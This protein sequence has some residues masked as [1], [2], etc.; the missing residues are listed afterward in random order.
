[1]EADGTNPVGI[2]DGA[3]NDSD[4]NWQPREVDG[5][6]TVTKTVVG[7]PASGTTFEITIDCD[8][9]D[10]DQVLTFGETG[11]TQVIERESFGPLE[12]QVT[13]TVTG[14]ATTV[15]IMCGAGKNAEC[16]EPG[17]FELFDD[18][19]GDETAIDIT[20]TDTFPVVVEPTFTG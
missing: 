18:P 1:M 17:V 10:D 2:S 5:D 20:V 6:V 13:E 14:G 15:E 9:D 16:T 19:G 11:G 4:P 7:T 8:D 3:A 12:C